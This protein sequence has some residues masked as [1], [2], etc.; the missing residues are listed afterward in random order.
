MEYKNPQFINLEKPETIFLKDLDDFLKR[1]TPSGCV[2]YL[3]EKFEYGDYDNWVHAIIE[4]KTVDPKFSKT[5]DTDQGIYK[6]GDIR[7][8]LR[9]AFWHY[10]E[11]YPFWL[12]K[13]EIGY[14][15]NTV[16]EKRIEDIKITVE[17]IFI[18]S[19]QDQKRIE[20]EYES[21]K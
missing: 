3:A 16:K 17:S 12:F 14:S 8:S 19:T 13:P 1:Y 7:F 11:N 9:D 4:S 21:R 10:R 15:T 6:A 20:A 18:I 2:A 5:F